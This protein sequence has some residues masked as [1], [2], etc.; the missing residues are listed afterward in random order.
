ML[1][2]PALDR[3]K[4]HALVVEDEVLVRALIAD[5][6]RTAGCAVIEANSADQALDYLVAG[7]K[8]DLMFSDIQM[9][10]SL[11]GL[12]LAERVRAD[13]PTVPVILTSGNDHL[14][15]ETMPGR[16]IAKPYDIAQTVALVFVTLG[17]A[18]PGTSA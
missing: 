2:E 1:P 18:P 14:N 3:E 17:V 12:Q 8:V 16:F 10:G 13:F 7:G 15:S 5:E 4:P 9:P 11:N 6:L